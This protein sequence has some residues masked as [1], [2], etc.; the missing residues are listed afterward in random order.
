MTSS[1]LPQWDLSDLYQSKE[2][3]TIT[4]DIADIQSQMS[5]FEKQYKGKI[6]TL[7]G[8]ELYK[9]IKTY[10]QTSEK[11]SKI[12]SYASLLHAVNSLDTEVGTFFQNMMDTA[13]S[14]SSSGLF[15]TLEL[16]KIEDA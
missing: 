9:C 13:R 6:A 11:L 1:A 4:N 5:E 2:D 16:N 10:E 7:S 14:V 8:D 3:T 15:F 12:I